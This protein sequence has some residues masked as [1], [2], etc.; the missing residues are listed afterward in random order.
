MQIKPVTGQ[1]VDNGLFIKHIQ[2]RLE[3]FLPHGCGCCSSDAS[4]SW[5]I[6]TVPDAQLV[7][8]M[9]EHAVVTLPD[10]APPSTYRLRMPLPLVRL[11]RTHEPGSAGTLHV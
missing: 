11:D 4:V 1:T 2:I 10:T 9:L 8:T 3:H 6:S 7:N 5:S